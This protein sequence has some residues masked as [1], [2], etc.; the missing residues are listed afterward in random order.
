MI[1]RPSVKCTNSRSICLRTI[2]TKLR[3]GLSA[4]VSLAFALWYEVKASKPTE[5][6]AKIHLSIDEWGFARIE[7]LSFDAYNEGPML[8][9]ALEAYKYHHGCYP[10]RVLVDQIYRTK[11]NIAFCQKNGNRISGPKLGRP[12]K[13]EALRKKDAKTAAQDHTDRI[14]IER[15][16]STA[17]R[18]NGMGLITKKR[19]DT[20]LTT[21]AFSVLVTNIFGSFKL[22]VEGLE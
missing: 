15:Y 11:L 7:Y 12:T 14:Q 18:R 8:I 9:Q 1:W 5:F 6:G 19:E 4:S 17:K 16:F 13:N 22:A 10:A 20:S 21:I 3:I 2:L